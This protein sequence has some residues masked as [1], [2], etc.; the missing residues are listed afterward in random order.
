MAKLIAVVASSI[1]SNEI[2]FDVAPVMSPD[3]PV[4]TKVT[5]CEPKVVKSVD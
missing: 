2:V 3:V 4:M 1:R 5:V